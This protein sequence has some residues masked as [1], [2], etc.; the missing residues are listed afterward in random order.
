ML[1]LKKKREAEVKAKTEEKADTYRL[2][3]CAATTMDTSCSSAAVTPCEVSSL[4]IVWE[5]K[6][7]KSYENEEP[8]RKK[9]TAC[10]IRIQRGKLS[11][12]YWR[13]KE[14]TFL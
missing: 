5:K 12:V 7:W 1:A 11:I 8:S 9:R 14:R 10:E 3:Q 2:A 4:G 13:R 6:A